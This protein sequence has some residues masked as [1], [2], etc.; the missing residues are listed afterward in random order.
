[1]AFDHAGNL[2]LVSGG[3]LEYTAAQLAAGV[4]TDPNQT[5][6][7]GDPTLQHWIS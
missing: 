7:V 5:L 4:Q 3:I 1:M 6:I 2:W